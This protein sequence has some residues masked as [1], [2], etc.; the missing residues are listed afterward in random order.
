[1]GFHEI[2]AGDYEGDPESGAQ[3]TYFAAPTQ[4]M[5]GNLAART[6]GAED[7]FEFKKRVDDSLASVAAEGKKSPV[8]FAHG[9]MI[10]V[11]SVMSAS[12]AAEYA[13]KLATDT[14]HNVGRVVVKGN[15]K[16]GWR[17]V[18][19]VGNPQLPEVADCGAGAPTIDLGS[20]VP[21]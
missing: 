19:W 5:R 3:A 15:P 2:L 16:K 18:E 6:P 21:C 17:I 4:W 1:P 10:M 13:P 8:I 9:A 12:N 11:W 14:L 20:L 7:G